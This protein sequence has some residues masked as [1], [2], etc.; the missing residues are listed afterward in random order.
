MPRDEHTPYL[1]N[2]PAYAIG[3]LDAEDVAALEAHLQTCASCR[4]ELAAYSAL[5]ESLLTAVP[6]KPPSAALRKRLQSRLPSAQKPARPQ[7]T[8]A[9][10]RLAMG[11]ALILLLGM[12]VYSILQTRTLQLEQTQLSRQIRT[13]QTVMSMLSY[14]GTERLSINSDQVVGSLLVDKE[15]D[16]VAMIVWN[17]PELSKDQT[18]QIWLI[19]PQ[20]DRVSGGIFDPE[21]DQ[22]YTTKIVY[23]KQSLTNFTG[24]GVTVE[25]A[26]GSDHPTGERIFKVD[27]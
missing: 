3:A 6:P 11:A 17:M 5:N 24:V 26:G 13:S 12:N 14:P 18:Y 4:T 16:M 2:I 19:D 25:P 20:G 1:E 23:P 27:F 9:F 8:F 15:R 21:T 10:S 22:P 7:G